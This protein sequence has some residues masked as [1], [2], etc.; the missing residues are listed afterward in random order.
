MTN[1]NYNRIFMAAN[2]N[3]NTTITS[4]YLHKYIVVK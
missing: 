3:I 4:A 1:A 2:T